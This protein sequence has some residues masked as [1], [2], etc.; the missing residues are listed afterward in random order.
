MGLFTISCIL[1]RCRG[2]CP[3]V[4]CPVSWIVSGSEEGVPCCRIFSGVPGAQNGRGS[5]ALISFR[6][7]GLQPNV[8]RTFPSSGLKLKGS[9]SPLSLSS[10][11]PP[12]SR[13]KLA[14]TTVKVL[15]AALGV[16][17]QVTVR[18]FSPSLSHFPNLC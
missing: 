2:F 6:A 16:R 17:F 3:H 18:F 5:A 13:E 1:L 8:K 12:L 10:A 11:L 9:V 4:P 7:P 14:L 15:K